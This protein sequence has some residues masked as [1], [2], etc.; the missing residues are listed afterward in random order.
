MFPRPWVAFA[1]SAGVAC[2]RPTPAPVPPS[3]PSRKFDY[4][5][6]SWMRFE[7][8]VSGKIATRL[9]LDT[10]GG[11]TLLSKQLCARAGCIPDGTFTGKRMSGQAL[12]I[13]M[14][15]VPSI[16]IAGREVKSARVAVMDTSSLLHPELGVEG[17]VGLDLFRD[18]PFTIHY[19]SRELVLESEFTLDAR[20]QAGEV[21]GVRVEHDGPSTVVYLPLQLANDTPALQMEVDSGSRDLILDERFMKMLEIDPTGAGVRRVTGRDE[22]AHEYV[23][24]FTKLANA[25]RVPGTS[26]IGVPAGAT[27]MF[28]KIIH[29]GLV[30]HAFLSA[31]TTTYDLRR[32][33][34]I[35][36]PL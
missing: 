25:A 28:Q 17:F 32:S 29:D 6:Q 23:R 34:M 31:H 18:Q 8:R 16:L 22:T 11:V 12:T 13:P 26:T 15:R 20:R 7:A 3:P 27:V 35:F 14:A 9:I 1:L 21:V 2:A 10:G 4:V 30:G 36:G 33:Q 5:G 24:W 19:R